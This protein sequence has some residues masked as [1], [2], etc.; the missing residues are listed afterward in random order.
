MLFAGRRCQA[1]GGAAGEAARRGA[2]SWPMWSGVRVPRSWL[3]RGPPREGR[4]G[5]RGRAE[6]ATRRGAMPLR[7]VGVAVRVESLG[8]V[9]RS[10]RACSGWRIVAGRCDVWAGVLLAVI[11]MR[12]RG[13]FTEV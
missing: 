1:G 11:A 12:I 9:G 4:H 8:R 3:G 10:W 6:I 7:L 2:F 13:E 5:S